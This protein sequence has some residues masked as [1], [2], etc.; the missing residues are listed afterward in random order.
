MRNILKALNQR[1]VAYYPIYAV[2]TGSIPC[3]V[4]LS[5]LLYWFSTSKDK[6]YKT[7]SELKEETGLSDKEVRTVKKKLK[8]LEFLNITREGV[9]ARTFYE[10]DWEKYQSSMSQWAKLDGQRKK[11]EEEDEPVCPNGTN[12]DVP[13]VETITESTQKLPEN[14][15]SVADK[16][17]DATPKAFTETMLD[18]IE[19]ATHLSTKL[20][21]SIDNYKQPSVAG[22][23]NW[24]RDIDLAIRKD[25]RT[26][27]QLIET[28]DWIHD[29][30]GSFWIGNIKSGKKLRS[31]FDTLTAQR[32][33]A[34]EKV[35]IRTK[36]LQA[37]GVGKP[38]FIFKDTNNDNRTVKVCL[39][40]D[41]NA[42]YDYNRSEYIAKDQANKAWDYIEKNFDVVL[43]NF[44]KGV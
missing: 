12:S 34:K 32:A 31:Q 6:I 35:N 29:G 9:P 23:H 14:T 15:S 26:K 3:A 11:R 44:K 40:G 42:L 37:F 20:S 27:Q 17:D 10:I 1:P 36:A 39:Y 21:E 25:N 2:G 30:E 24:T 43:A 5:Q 19:V 38:F 41:Y 33:P 8:E 22:L 16:S 18:A 13:M 28:I 7:D 4:A